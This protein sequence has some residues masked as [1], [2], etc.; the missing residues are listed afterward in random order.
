MT[1]SFQIVALDQKRNQNR[2]A[3]RALSRELASSDKVMVCFGSMFVQL[4][5]TKTKDMLQRDQEL[6]DEEIA[7]LRE[8]LKVK[9]GRLLEAQGICRLGPAS[10]KPELK[11]YDLKPLSGEEMW[12]IRKVLEG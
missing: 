5:N 11:G 3:L 9:V 10:G 8:E 1:L 2:E 12:F 6:L 7:G 4:P